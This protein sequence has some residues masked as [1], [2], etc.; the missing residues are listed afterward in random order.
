V[1]RSPI[2]GSGVFA[3]QSIPARR[4]VIEYVGERISRLETRRRFLRAWTSAPGRRIYLARLDLYWAIDGSRGGS[5][6]ELINHYCAP[7]LA[8]RRIRGRLYFFSTRKIRRGEEL[9]LDYEFAADGPKVRCR[10]GAATCR[11]TINLS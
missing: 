3:L 11:G 1:R 9:T 4:K 10:C 5:G 6:A 7:N 8:P 2:H